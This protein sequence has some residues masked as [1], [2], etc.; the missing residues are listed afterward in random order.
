MKGPVVLLIVNAVLSNT[1]VGGDGDKPM[2]KVT[3]KKS[4]D[5]VEVRA[6]KDKTV[7]VIK[8]PSG[9]SQTFIERTDEKWPEKMLFRLNLKGL[10]SFRITN[11]KVKLEASVSSQNGTVRL[12]KDGKENVL[13]D[14]KSPHWMEIRLICSDGKAVKEIPLKDGYF[15]MQLPQ[16]FFEGNP[17]S[18]TLNW[19]DFYRN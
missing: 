7:Y 19:I 8:S 15:E 1:A 2:F 12:W 14:D 6:D 3:S 9:I 10:E 18:I 16:A 11:D 4:D 13:L 5:A 17:K